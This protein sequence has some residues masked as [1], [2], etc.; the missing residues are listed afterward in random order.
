VVCT[1]TTAL[2]ALWPSSA[3]KAET[4]GRLPGV[5]V[6]PL[7]C[8]H[9]AHV[10]T[11]GLRAQGVAMVLATLLRPALDYEQVLSDADVELYAAIARMRLRPACPWSTSQDLMPTYP[12][13]RAPGAGLAEQLGANAHGGPG[14]RPCGG[15]QSSG[16]NRQLGGTASTV[17]RSSRRTHSYSS[18][19]TALGGK[20]TGVER[21]KHRV[22][23]G[24]AGRPVRWRAASTV[25]CRT[26]FGLRAGIPKP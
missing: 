9:G 12:P 11:G 26:T 7:V 18:A 2:T 3:G 6:A 19:L 15:L 10:Q 8:V 23:A 4:L 20:S 5:P 17:P 25:R 24:V 21:H 14:G 22:K 13:A 16:S 1:T